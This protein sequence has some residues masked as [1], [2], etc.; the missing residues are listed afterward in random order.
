MAF[1][2]TELRFPYVTNEH[3]PPTIGDDITTE[4][5]IYAVYIQQE[6]QTNGVSTIVYLNNTMWDDTFSTYS[7]HTKY[8]STQ[9][10]KIP[11]I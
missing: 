4:Q 5:H 3:Y 11:D 10:F 2:P 1:K 7:L 8:I 9:F 6:T